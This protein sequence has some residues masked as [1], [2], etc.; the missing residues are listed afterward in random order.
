[1][2]GTIKE[3]IHIKKPLKI[4]TDNPELISLGEKSRKENNFGASMYNVSPIE[5]YIENRSINPSIG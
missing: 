2:Y 1:M 3:K 5:V 4:T